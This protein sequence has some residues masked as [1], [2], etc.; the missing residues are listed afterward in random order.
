MTDLKL[1]FRSLRATPIV[2]T[3]AVLSLALGI[4]ANTAIFSLVDG[5]VL[6]P[7]PVPEPHRL[8]LLSTSARRNVSGWSVPIWEEI[9]RRPD[10]FEQAAGWSP[11]RLN[12]ATGGETQFVDAVWA[13]GS[14]FATLG[15]R[16]LLGRTFSED[17][18]RPGGGTGGPV[19]VISYG[20]W[21][22]QFGGAPDVIGRRLA[23][24][25]VPVS[26]LS[27]GGDGGDVRSARTTPDGRS[28]APSPIRA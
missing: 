22:R 10:L 20:F 17:D 21:Q 3:V 6:R 13:T 23:I 8:V 7:L 19:V 2:T 26:R 25:G 24:H 12:L 28:A 1:A 15:V 11:T 18:D 16:A 4:G 14:F 5:L 27:F 9:R